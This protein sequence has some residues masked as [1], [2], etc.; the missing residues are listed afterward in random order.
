M[1]PP[2]FGPDNPGATYVGHVFAERTIDTGEA[3]INYAVTGACD[4]PAL[5]LIPGQTESWW[6]Y[7]NAMG[8]LQEH[9]QAFAIDLRGQGRSSRTPGRSKTCTATIRSNRSPAFAHSTT[10]RATCWCSSNCTPGQTARFTIRPM[11]TCVC[12]FLKTSSTS[13][14]D[15]SRFPSGH[16]ARMRSLPAFAARMRRQRLDLPRA[17]CARFRACPTRM[18]Q[19]QKTAVRALVRRS[20]KRGE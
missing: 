8:L 10:G 11:R 1:K 14:C 2:K 3:V 9:F 13:P 6:G 17:R 15:S 20:S 7:E 19:A 16:S 18:T 5:L 4:K 12:G